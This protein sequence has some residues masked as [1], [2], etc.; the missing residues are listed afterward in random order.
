MAVIVQKYGGSSVATLDKM[1]QI[2]D[3]IIGKASEGYQVV[4]VVSAMGKTTNELITMAQQAYVN[5]CKRELDML[6]STGEQMSAAL[7]SI[8]INGK[9]YPS[10][11][12]TGSQ[13]GIMTRG[14]H[15]RSRILDI[16]IGRVQRHLDQGKVVI[17]AGFQGFN[18]ND[19]ITT[20]GR[21]GSDTTAV[22][23]AA[24]LGSVCEIYTD[25]AGIYSVDPRRY[26]QARKLDHISYEEMKEMSH[27][28]AKVMETRSVEIG[29]RFGVPI[30]VGL[31]H[32]EVPGTYIQEHDEAM[33]QR[34]L[35]GLSVSEDVLMVTLQSIPYTPANVAQVFT[36]LAKEEVLVDMISQTS[37]I[38]GFVNISFTT[39]KGD[40]HAVEAVLSPFQ[41]KFPDANIQYDDTIAK[42]SVVG[43][44]MRTQ[45]GVAAK[46]FEVFAENNIE[47]KQVSTS[48]ISISYTMSSKSVQRAVEVIA[49]AFGLAGESARA[50][51]VAQ[52]ET[53]R[54]DTK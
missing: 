37:P 41:R 28:G 15:T 35:T 40:M 24:K 13:A 2:A 17:V 27:L 10:V 54:D 46:L 49:E 52:Y 32:E 14:R 21:G 8:I 18:E 43:L 51:E 29:H 42:V 6:M 34:S 20:L 5:P 12:L 45:S 3:K 53:E 36:Q 48:E 26:K 19:D 7:M 31:S 33:E 47:F 23:L 30:Y 16:D 44:G 9:G 22:A 25:V 1:Q 39:A 38:Q 50:T 11:S 4:V